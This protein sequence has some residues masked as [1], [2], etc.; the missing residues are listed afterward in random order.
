MRG[1][2]AILLAVFLLCLLCGCVAEK[3]GTQDIDAA[4]TA[5]A[6]GNFMEAERLYESYLQCNAQ[7]QDR[8]EAWNRLLDIALNVLGNYE[9]STSLLESM[10]LEFAENPEQAW[11]LT[12]KLAQLQ[13]DAKHWNEAVVTWQSAL[14]INGLQDTRYPEIYLHLARIY[15]QRQAVDLAEEALEACESEARLP[16]TKALCLYELAQTL[17]NTQRRIEVQ[18]IALTPEQVRAFDPKKNQRRIKELLLRIR[19]LDGV[20]SERKALA[21]FMLAGVYENTGN[22]PQ[23]ITLLESIHDSYPNPKVV[24]VR[25]AYLKKKSKKKAVHVGNPDQARI[26]Q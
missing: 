16:E 14:E 20:G 6:N 7:G 1:G 3:K 19:N 17:E 11:R 13:E 12:S 25:L 8:W 2:L 5:Y 21:G 15:R 4:R 18:S 10:S 9:K 22:I 26:S 23:A 24:E